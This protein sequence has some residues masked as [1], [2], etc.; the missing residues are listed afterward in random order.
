VL[1]WLAVLLGIIEGL[2][3][4]IPV[5]STGHLILAAEF[6]N[7]KDPAIDSF[8]IFIQLGAILAAALVYRTQFI[9]L[10]KLG[11][12]PSECSMFRGVYAWKLLL[13]ACFPAV[14]MGLLFHSLIKEHLFN[15]FTVALALVCGGI[16]LLIF[17]RPERFKIKARALGEITPRQSLLIGI[18][19]CL[20][21]WPGMSRSGSTII[22]S[23][24]LGLNRRVAA[25][26]SFILAVPMIAMAT[27]Y[28]LYKSWA[29]LRAEYLSFFFV[30]FIVSFITAYF[31]IR[32]FLKLIGRYSF[33]P[34][35][36]YRIIIGLILL[37][38]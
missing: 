21:L 38:L 37:L 36:W 17:D 18:F 16:L 19:Q 20:A 28:D 29:L 7:L 9:D 26:F 15:Q 30:G 2:T 31:A 22:G 23:L 4:F 3:E 5:S 24:W 11:R 25:D 6:F 35:A 1:L 34:F 8:L 32:F 27:T 14:L 33:A 10:F 12:Q 13:L